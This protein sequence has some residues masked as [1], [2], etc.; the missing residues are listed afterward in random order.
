MRRFRRQFTAIFFYAD[1]H[2]VRCIIG[3]AEMIWAVTLLWQ[4]NTFIR[5]AYFEMAK[6]ATEEAWGMVFI[7]SSVTQFGIVMK[8]DYHSRFSTYFA[9]WNFALWLFVTISMYMSVFPPPAAISGETAL[10]IAA[11]WIWIRSGYVTPGR[12]SADYNE[13]SDLE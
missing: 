3:L 8:G 6:I 10:M 5:P 13:L 2:A 12:R 4:G 1:L 7:I 9:G 11:G